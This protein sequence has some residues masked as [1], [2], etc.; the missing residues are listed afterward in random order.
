[1]KI[2]LLHSL[3]FLLPMLASAQTPAPDLAVNA[4]AE[5]KALNPGLPTLFVAGDSTAAK[6]SGGPIQGWAVPFADYF[7]SAKINVVNLARGGRSTRTF[8]SEGLWDELLAQVKAGDF[9]LI[10]FGHN[11]GSPV[12]EDASVPREKWRSRGSLPGLGE[13]TSEIDNVVT[14]KH[15]TI[16]TFGWYVRK[17]VADVKA[18]GATP[19]ILSL[20]VRDIWKDGKVERGSGSFRRW[21]LEIAE[22][23]GVAFVDVT[24][25]VADQYQALG[26]EK[27][28]ALYGPD[29]THPNGAGADL[30]AA[31]VV[32]GLKGIRKG[33][34]ASYLSAKGQT[35]EADSI[36]WLNLPEP[37]DPKLPSIVLVGDSL[38]RNGRDDGEGGQWGWGDFLAD[39]FAP[40][41]INVAN[42]AVGGLSSRTY[43]TQGHWERALTLIKPGDFVVIQLGHNDA[44]PLNDDK[45]ARGTIKGT[46]EETEEIDNILTKRHEVV[47]SYGWYIRKI[48]RETRAAGATPIVCSHT[49]RKT[50]KDGKIVRSGVDSYGGWARQVAEQEKAAFLDVNDLV[51]TRYEMI[52]EAAV[53]PLFGDPNLHTSLAGAKVNAEIVAAALRALPGDPLGGFAK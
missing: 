16:H 47:H 5:K 1:M 35:V 8:I 33:P 49:P 15:E 29:H 23:A 18:K 22:Q 34:W 45:R 46:G 27:V 12:N 6:Y 50:W 2:T 32:A 4:A 51:A 24:R 42:R 36:G 30:H 20:T 37:A 13:E 21:D 11:D 48:V 41:R 40:A 10:Q 7:D 28:H 43:L 14:K 3:L 17:M 52:G 31:A 25:I 53:N 39:H 38:V 9:V 19:V 26:A 44:S